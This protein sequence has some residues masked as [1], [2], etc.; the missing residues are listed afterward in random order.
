MSF[1]GKRRIG[2][3]A[4]LVMIGAVG[5]WIA[6]SR[7]QTNPPVRFASADPGLASAHDLSEAFV[8]VAEKVRPAVVKI[9]VVEKVQMRGSRRQMPDIEETPFRD[10]FEEFFGPDWRRRMVPPEGLERQGLGSGVIV[11]ANN[12]Y[13]LTNYHVVGEADEITVTLNDQREFDA[14]VIG[15]D[16]ASDVA[17]IQ[18]KADN[19]TAAPL[20]RS[21][22]LRVGEIVVAIGSPLNLSGTVTQGIVSATGRRA[23]ILG[24]YGFENFIQTDAAINVGN[25]GGPLVNLR[26]E[27]IGI[28]SAIATGTGSFLGVGFAVPID[29]ARDVMQD[30]IT[31][32]RVVRGYL[33]V[34]IGPVTNEFAH[35]YGLESPYGALVQDVVSDGPAA[36]AGLQSLDLIV[37]INGEK[38]KSQQWFLIRISSMDPGDKVHLKVIRDGQTKEFTATL[39]ERPGEDALAKLSGKPSRGPR[40]GAKEEPTSEVGSLGLT[41]Q[42][43][44]EELAQRL[45]VEQTEG[46]VVTD[47]K[48]GSLASRKGYRP[49]MVITEVERTPVSSAAD[50]EAQVK[51]ALGERGSVLLKVIVDGA[52]HYEILEPKAEAK[53]KSKK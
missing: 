39:V 18:I 14:K 42:G 11:D 6:T 23:D 40:G 47:V 41:V 12:G 2:G 52:P 5:V 44:N 38:V 43:L 1:R 22:D 25:S 30:L 26:G 35:R 31:K 17:V 32:G 16:K 49:G 36:K 51:K 19:L 13:I 28:N 15:A 4:M 10:F 21:E 45:G 50:F 37:E 29:M 24:D 3:L 46:V 33:G 27:I 8:A 53:G 7:A 20:G 34:T 9:S 48:A